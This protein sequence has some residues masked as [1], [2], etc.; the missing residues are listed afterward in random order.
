M[1]LRRK[2]FFKKEI[3]QIFYFVRKYQVG[4]E[5]LY[6]FIC[7]KSLIFLKKALILRFLPTYLAYLFWKIITYFSQLWLLHSYL[8]LSVVLSWVVFSQNILQHNYFVGVIPT[9][10]LN[11]S[12]F[13][14]VIPT[15]LSLTQVFLWVV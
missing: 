5:N 15:H 1:F 2:F 8:L 6:N 14:G 10:I 12:I 13:M 7:M 3:P 11:G 4:M 9:Q